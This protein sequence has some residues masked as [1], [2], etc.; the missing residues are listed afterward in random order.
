[1]ETPHTLSKNEKDLLNALGR[2]PD[3]SMKELLGYT[4][5]KQVTTVARKVNQFK[6]Q[7]ILQGPVYDL[8]YS[9][10]CKNPLHKLY[11][12]LETAQNYETVISYIKL[13]E[14]IRFIFPA[15]SPHKKILVAVFY[16]SNDQGTVSLLDL[17]KDNN[18]I[19]DYIVHEWCSKRMVENPN[20]FGDLTPSLNNLLD[21]CEI[22]DI[23]LECHD[24][25]W[26]E[27]DITIIPYLRFNDTK[28]IEILRKEKKLQKSWTYEQV[29]YSREKML[30]N[31]LIEKKYA[32]FPFSPDQSTFFDLFLELDDTD[33]TERILFNF[34]KNGRVYKEYVLC[35]DGGMII[36]VCHHLFLR[37]VLHKLD[38]VNQIKEK[39]LYPLRSITTEHQ[40]S[41]SI[42]LKYYD[43]DEQTLEY[44]YHVYKEEIKGKLER[45]MV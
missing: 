10:L 21:P 39:E 40:F 7:M 42:V 27:C 16:F 29:R 25:D 22:P 6:E 41:Q 38:Q 3:A 1:M 17:L 32:V 5:Y 13:I 19:T 34:A 15:L 35:K 45:E 20:F 8:N 36:C 9:K 12:I 14:P 4:A 23:F 11:C 33:L 26:N 2:F 28:L 37:D 43:F 30:K 44:P 18:I 24:T 31:G